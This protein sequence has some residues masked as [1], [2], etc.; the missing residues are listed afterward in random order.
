MKQVD[1]I[2]GQVVTMIVLLCAASAT[3]AQADETYY[4]PNT[5]PPD[6]FLALRTKPTAESG[7]RL[8]TMPNGTPVKVLE[9]RAD[10][11][12]YVRVLPSGPEGWAL[13]REGNRVWI[14]CCATG[15]IAPGTFG[16]T[17]TRCTVARSPRVFAR[18]VP[19]GEPQRN[20]GKY[21]IDITGYVV[22]VQ[23]A[24]VF[25]GKSWADVVF[26]SYDVNHG[27]V[28]YKYFTG[29]HSEHVRDQ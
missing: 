19:D 22:D 13:S 18:K 12:W 25:K 9:R 4:V 21:P 5:R 24:T 16:H 23:D 20:E 8:A 11:W 14:V 15:E 26:D 7:D 28:E 3:Q 29:C 27:W 1:R 2:A 10:G 6:A 17:V